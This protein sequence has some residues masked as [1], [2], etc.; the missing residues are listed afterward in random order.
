MGVGG[1]RPEGKYVKLPV[2]IRAT[3]LGHSY[4]SIKSAVSGID[5]DPDTNVFYRELS[6]GLSEIQECVLRLFCLVHLAFCG[7]VD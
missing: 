6:G 5:Y 7:G 4:R 2:V 3:R 1:H